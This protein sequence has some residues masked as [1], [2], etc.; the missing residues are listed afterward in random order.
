MYMFLPQIIN[1]GVGFS[2][3]WELQ[4]KADM[5]SCQ[6]QENATTWK[7]ILFCSLQDPFIYTKPVSSWFYMIFPHVS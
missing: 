6:A 5:L 2:F 4:T 3:K 7:E 1:V